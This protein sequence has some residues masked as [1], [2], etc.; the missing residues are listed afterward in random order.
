[1]RASCTNLTN[2]LQTKTSKNYNTS[3]TTTAVYL[4][5][6]TSNV[7]ADY[8]VDTKDTAHSM[9]GNPVI[10]ASNKPAFVYKD[11]M[12]DPIQI[13]APDRLPAAETWGDETLP[14]PKWQ[15]FECNIAPVVR[16]FRAGV[17]RGEYHEETLAIWTNGSYE[18]FVGGSNYNFKPPW[19]LDLGV[20]PNK[21]FTL[22]KRSIMSIR[23]FFTGFFPGGAELT[24]F[25]FKF[26]ETGISLYA[27]HDLMQL[28]ALSNITNCT[29]R[30]TEKLHCAMDNVA[31]AM[32]KAIRDSNSSSSPNFTTTTGQAMIATTH[33]TIHWQWITLP[34][35][36]WL[37]GLITLLGTMWKTRR[38]GIP[39]WKNETM[40]ILS[41]Y[42]DGSNEKPQGD[43]V[44]ETD[45]VR[46]YESEGKMV[47]S[48]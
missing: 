15:A 29:T 28:I 44:L 48:G 14:Q 38:A 40:P 45:R 26:I 8:Q 24:P 20:E 42:R 18:S 12:I 19:G 10:I 32:T 3:I 33:V 23:S 2:Q 35:L 21:Q 30:T 11:S 27:S 39:T 31:L 1:M 16:S 22:T 6:P 46:F 37:L 7:S 17:T 13:I 25:G 4:K 47:L 34:V 43:Q 36:V 5:G 41:V 9:W